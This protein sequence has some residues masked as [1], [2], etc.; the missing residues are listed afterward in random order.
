MRCLIVKLLSVLILSALSGCAL[1]TEEQRAGTSGRYEDLIAL[2]EAELR[3]ISRA[4]TA[5]LIPL[6]GAYAGVKRYNQLFP[7]LDQLERNIAAGDTNGIDNEAVEE[8]VKKAMGLFYI[9]SKKPLQWVANVS[10]Q[11]HL[12]RAQALLELGDYAGAIAAARKAIQ[13]SR[14]VSSSRAFVM[15]QADAYVF[16]A[17]SIGAVAFA[18]SGDRAAAQRALAGMETFKGPP[19][20]QVG[21]YGRQLGFAKVYAAL[22]DY[23]KSLGFAQQAEKSIA[24]LSEPTAFSL[25]DP[26]L[27]PKN[28]LGITMPV[29]FLRVKCLFE[30]GRQQEARQG[31]DEMLALPQLAQN[32]EIYWPVLYDRGRIALHEN[33][34]PAAIDY[35]SRAVEVI[36]RQR[37][38]I[39][40]EAS[41][42]GFVGDKQAVYRQ[43]I[44]ALFAE[45]RYAEAFDYL[46]RS[47]SRALVDMLARKQ[48]FAIAAADAAGVRDLLAQASVSEFEARAAAQP[49]GV[50][51][52]Q[53]NLTVQS[54]RSAIAQ[55]AP[56]LATL[57]SVSST[58]LA[59]I[60]ALIPAD[61]ALL[62]YYYD[63]EA[64][65]AFVLT[66]QGLQGARLRSSGL[67]DEVRLLRQQLENPLPGNAHMETAQ[68]LYARLIAPL[69]GMLDK[70]KLLIVPHGA[71][72][73]LPFAALHDGTDFLLVRY[74]LRM[75]PSASVIKHLRASDTAKPG[76]ILAFGNPDLG[77]P[78]Y[79]LR[80]AQEEA[81]GI[82]K[83]V[84]QSRA[85]LRKEATESALRR[86]GSGFAYLHFAT[87]GQFDAQAPLKSALLLTPE[88]G[89]NGL[90]TVD[91]LYSMRLDASLVTLSACET[92]LGKVASGDDVVGLTRGFLYAGTSTIVASLW[93]VDDRAT[94]KLMQAFYENLGTLSK[95]EALRRAQLQTR[96]TFAHPYY[97]AAF[98]LTGRAE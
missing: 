87:H 8:Q 40:T 56:E 97:W 47:K 62:E 34:R 70:P 64:L 38:T 7:C 32:G 81:Q 21:A 1:L 24:I 3:D 85:L 54:A 57:V 33:N 71:L 73:Y 16:S 83:V 95:Q 9:A 59:E 44:A 61:E 41:R 14:G 93:K 31:Y 66:R 75:L 88:G 72:H 89:N 53:R 12:L 39:N 15:M 86:Y 29:K 25:L 28:Y 10:P 11:P 2:K 80:Y 82:I 22:G 35:W 17:N 94:A 98:Q 49:G 63:D 5:K 65:Y 60:L 84:P 74:A 78:Q 52:G 18:L 43:L 48:D 42:I 67:E 79:D 55:Q 77:D 69:E 90:L 20:D 96:Q 58:T 37:A 51:G 4:S 92:G 23:Q 50:R 46:E 45:R 91:K 6:C 19:P 76:G 36:E 26:D 30:V 27:D 68:K 13:S